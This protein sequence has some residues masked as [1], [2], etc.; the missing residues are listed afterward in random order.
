MENVMITVIQSAAAVAVAAVPVWL[1]IRSELKVVKKNLEKLMDHLQ[2]DE[3]RK[4][5][6]TK[7]LEWRDYYLRDV[8][9][10]FKTAICVKTTYLI[11][12]VLWTVDHCG[13]FYSLPDLEKVLNYYDST[14]ER[15]RVLVKTHT[16]QMF[17]DIYFSDKYES[18]FIEFR[19][20]TVQLFKD[21]QN[22]KVIRYYESAQRF[23]EATCKN[24]AEAVAV[25]EKEASDERK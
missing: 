18:A 11:D 2:V 23:L 25:Y 24:Y 8:P 21:F 16:C 15:S 19:E 3:D 4:Q 22:N 10:D 5:W 14:Y 9:D 13:G 7:L 6:E 20:Y 12:G 17:A 1:Q